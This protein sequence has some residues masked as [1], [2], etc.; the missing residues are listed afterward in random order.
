MAH[1]ILRAELLVN[2]VLSCP[3]KQ[4]AHPRKKPILKIGLLRLVRYGRGIAP[5]SVINIERKNVK[6][7]TALVTINTQHR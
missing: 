7:K 3:R 2:Q 1:H 5:V 4:R 6:C